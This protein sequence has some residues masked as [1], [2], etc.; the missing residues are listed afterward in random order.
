M[1]NLDKATELSYQVAVFGEY[2]K[3]TQTPMGST[4]VL[5]LAEMV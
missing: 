5:S 4:K 1:V 3:H 2:V